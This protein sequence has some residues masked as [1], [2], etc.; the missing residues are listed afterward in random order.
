MT[1]TCGLVASYGAECR[2]CYEDRIRRET[3]NERLKTEA[4]HRYVYKGKGRGK[5][6][7]R[8]YSGEV[9]GNH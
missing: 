5:L 3:R 1:C 6:T 7:S 8:A 2:D 4:A 9:I